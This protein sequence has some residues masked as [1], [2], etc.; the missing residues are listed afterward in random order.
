[1]INPQES[2]VL[3]L[4][5]IHQLDA[6]EDYNWKLYKA[7]IM[8]VKLGY[9][10]LPIVK[11]GKAIP[12]KK[13]NLAYAH[14]T[15]K[16]KVVE[17]WFDPLDGKFA[18]WNLGIA[19]GREQGVFVVDVDNHGEIDGF[20]TLAQI[21]EDEKEIMP[22]GPIQ[23]TPNEGEHFVY[24]WQEDAVSSTEKIGPGID[25]RGGTEDACKGHI[26]VW[27]SVIDGKSYKWK[28]G[29]PVPF[30]PDWVMNRLGVSW[31]T[32]PKQ[33]E[34]GGRGNENVEDSDIEE[35]VPLEQVERMLNNINPDD[36]GYD[37]WVQIGMAIRSQHPIEGLDVW[38]GWSSHGE[39]YK[40][41]ECALRWEGFS[42][43]GPVRI[44]TLFW[45]AQKAGYTHKPTD[46]K[47]NK[48]AMVVERINEDH[49]M[50]V[51]G[52]KIR[53]LRENVQTTDDKMSTPY[54]LLSRQDFCTLT[55]NDRILIDPEKMKYLT[56]SS[57]W[58]ADQARRTFPNGLGMFPE[59]EPEGYYNTWKGFAIDPVPGDCD[60]FKDHIL[61]IVCKGNDFI[62]EYVLDWCADLFQNPEDPKGVAI[63]MRGTEGVGKGTFAN[64]IGLM[65]A[66]HYT[67]LID[68]NH[69][70]G[71]FN[72]HLS[73]SVFV[74]ADE[75]TWGGNVKSAGKLKGLVTERQMLLERKGIDA[76]IQ[77]NLVH[78]MIASNSQW[79]IPA[80]VDS[81]RWLVLDVAR[82]R[83][84]DYEYFDAVQTEL[85]SGGKE[86][87]LFEMMNRKI[88]NNLRE[89]PN[90][91]ALI[92]QR[93]MSV[94][95]EDTQL[96][97][98]RS[99][100]RREVMQS[101]DLKDV[102]NVGWPRFVKKSDIYDEYEEWCLHRRIHAKADNPF[103]KEMLR[104]GMRSKKI[105]HLGQRMRA[106]EVPGLPAAVDYINVLFGLP[107]EKEDETEE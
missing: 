99:V 69:L 96:R 24:Q 35:Q 91:E 36:L 73:D 2:D 46:K 5:L 98:W 39:R 93:I 9:R 85:E 16:L 53:I 63:V 12:P 107:E 100:L 106:F 79:V 54:H 3:D 33:K 23:S 72:S 57:I 81:R 15:N 18:G 101:E 51:T 66:P 4:T 29:G 22:L 1:M 41:G 55:E 71:Q 45:H 38:D 28:M 74:F 97:W 21:L 48:F 68:E 77:R 19:T 42:E 25:T 26:V 89:A 6:I 27:P 83:K 10:I 70:T 11:N 49:C 104:Y 32:R 60:M 30:V 64:T 20:V 34:S 8:Y 7:A 90:T 43:F 50:V 86:A 56:V 61:K 13:Y 82:D 94:T 44:A 14:A 105:S 95:Q 76:V 40:E 31:S 65:C 67:H 58:L 62:Y 80:G 47:P 92:E 75:I 103:F 17:T 88:T 78:M 84:S 59:G 52:N 102:N 37:E 87:F